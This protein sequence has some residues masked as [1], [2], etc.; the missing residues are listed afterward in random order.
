MNL[1]DIQEPKNLDFI[2]FERSVIIKIFSKSKYLGCFQ[3]THDITNDYSWCAYKKFGKKNSDEK[4]P[5]PGGSYE[6]GN[7]GF[8]TLEEA[9]LD[10][11]SNVI[12]IFLK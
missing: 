8:K 5:E 7:Q 11:E 3:I 6:I 10:A 12:A 1:Q 4:L 9:R 2:S